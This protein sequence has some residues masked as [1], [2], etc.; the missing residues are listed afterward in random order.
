MTDGS[1]QS[2]TLPEVS[3]AVPGLEEASATAAEA[4][5]AQQLSNQHLPSVGT[6]Q[7]DVVMSDVPVGNPASPVPG[8]LAPSPAPPRIGTPGHGSR[9]AS[10]HPDAGFAMPSEA[11]VHGDSARRYLNTRVTGVLLE[12]MK[13]LAKDQPNDPLRVLG[14]YLIQRSKELEGTG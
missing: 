4:A 8:N 2:E 13:Q 12:G 7:R 5:I 6:P 14:E 9:A 3:P 10:L 1:A 11:P